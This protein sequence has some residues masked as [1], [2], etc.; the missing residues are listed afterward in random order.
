MPLQFLIQFGIVLAYE[1]G[2]F[3]SI[4]Y[5]VNSWLKKRKLNVV[6]HNQLLME[7]EYGDI[8]KD[9]DVVA[10]E[11]R[12]SEMVKTDDFNVT[13]RNEIFIIDKLTKYYSNFMAVKGISFTLK[14]TETFGL[15]GNNNNNGFCLDK[16]MALGENNEQK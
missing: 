1:A 3:R 11:E 2:Y 7:L 15:L 6:N 5:L 16:L 14:S 9:T 4:K 8:R 13:G 10:E 12:I